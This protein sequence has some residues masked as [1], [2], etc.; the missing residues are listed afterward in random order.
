MNGASKIQ[1]AH[2]ERLAVV[3]VRQSSP[4]QLERNRESTLRQYNFVA[5]ATALGWSETSWREVGVSFGSLN[6]RLVRRSTV[7]RYA[8]PNQ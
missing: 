6:G 3:Y 5:R 1:R 7:G 4:T 8:S 2:R